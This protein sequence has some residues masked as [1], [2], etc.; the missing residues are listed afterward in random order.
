M[1]MQIRTTIL[2]TYK[3]WFIAQRLKHEHELVSMKRKINARI[4]S[5]VIKMNL[6]SVE[7]CVAFTEEN[8]IAFNPTIQL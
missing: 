4:W 7:N 6:V 8:K 1:E 3:E 5:M 2:D